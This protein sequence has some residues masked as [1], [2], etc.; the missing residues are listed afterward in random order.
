MLPMVCTHGWCVTNHLCGHRRTC[1]ARR[2]RAMRG[3]LASHHIFIAFG[4]NVLYL[5]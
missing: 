1:Y 4:D 3:V 5:Q 2:P